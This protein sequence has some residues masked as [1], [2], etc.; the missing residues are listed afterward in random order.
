MNI[1]KRLEIMKCFVIADVHSFYNEMIEALDKAGFDKNN[2]QHVL[3]SLGD[4]LD[5]G[6]DPIKC[7]EFINS[8]DRKILIR[9]NHEDLMEKAIERK[10][11][12]AHDFHNRT[13]DTVQKVLG[14]P[15][16]ANND[17]AMLLMFS[18]CD[19]WNKYIKSCIDYAET[20]KYIFVHGWIPK[21]SDWR[22]GDWDSAR[23]IN[24]MK[25]W[26]DSRKEGRE[27]EKTILCGH[28]HTSWGHHYIEHDCPEWDEDIEMYR[29]LGG[30]N[31]K[32]AN[33]TPFKQKGIIALDACTAI[34]G[35]V[36]C[37][38]LTI[39]KKQLE[40]YL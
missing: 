36:N 32:D 15:S 7:L 25:E 30:T 26:E 1:I 29:L 8:L 3:I 39:G 33:F 38:V 40:K 31:I 17:L 16:D 21:E 9:G 23:W 13:Y 20:D 18:E 35:F 28:Y 24:G 37:Q 10:M 5:R 34:S 2:P 12:L 27:Q 11:F 6:P 22:N 19:L 4:L 14:I